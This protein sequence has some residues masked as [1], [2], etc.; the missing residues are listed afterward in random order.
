MVY[1]RRKAERGEKKERK[2]KQKKNVTFVFPD[3]QFKNA[4]VH[5]VIALKKKGCIVCIRV[6]TSE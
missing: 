2:K 5:I 1:D 4:R 6:E 3:E